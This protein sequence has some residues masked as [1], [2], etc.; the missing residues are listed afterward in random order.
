MLVVVGHEIAFLEMLGIG[1]PGVWHSTSVQRK[2]EA[3]MI[4][5]Q[6]GKFQLPCSEE[7]L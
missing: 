7:L 1:A 2:T 6:F 5:R 3:R 4:E